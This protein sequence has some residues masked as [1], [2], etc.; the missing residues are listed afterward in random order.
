MLRAHTSIS[1]IIAE[2]GFEEK[3]LEA[4]GKKELK[5]IMLLGK[6]KRD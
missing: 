4:R 3:W 5:D 2:E 6:R 1:Q